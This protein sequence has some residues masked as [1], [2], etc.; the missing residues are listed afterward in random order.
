M[1]IYEYRCEECGEQFEVF[2]RSLAKMVTPT[3]PKCGGQKVGKS[4]SLFGTS[5]TSKGGAAAASSCGPG[6]V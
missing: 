3:C 5:G 6:P 1:P 4:V 2:V